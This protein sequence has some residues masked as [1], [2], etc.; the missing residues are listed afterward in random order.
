MSERGERPAVEQGVRLDA[1]QAA[2]AV[3]MNHHLEA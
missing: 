1:A 3:S 2:L